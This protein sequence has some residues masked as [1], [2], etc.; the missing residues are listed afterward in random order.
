MAVKIVS[1]NDVS[2][3]HLNEGMSTFKF[4]HVIVGKMQLLCII[5]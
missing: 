5:G 1:R 2:S 3:E 4:T